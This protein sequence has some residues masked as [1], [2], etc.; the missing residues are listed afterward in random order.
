MENRPPEIHTQYSRPQVTA[1]QVETYQM[2]KTS[3]SEDRRRPSQQMDS[4]LSTSPTATTPQRSI[5]SN[6]REVGRDHVLPDDRNLVNSGEL[7]Q[8]SHFVLFILLCRVAF[9]DFLTFC[10]QSVEGRKKKTKMENFRS[11]SFS[12]SFPLSCTYLIERKKRSE[13]PLC[14]YPQI[15]SSQQFIHHSLS[16]APTLGGSQQFYGGDRGVFDQPR[17]YCTTPGHFTPLH[18]GSI[19]GSQCHISPL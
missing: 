9:V 8:T 5:I 17:E 19:N 1:A 15:Y 10:V 14:H 18:P 13:P 6:V 7:L 16:T 2:T 11:R 3:Q 4:S 12:L